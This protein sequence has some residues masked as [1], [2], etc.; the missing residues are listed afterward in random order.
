MIRFT[1]NKRMIWSEDASPFPVG[2]V[3]GEHGWASD[4]MASYGPTAL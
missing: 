3:G 4:E 2:F 1:A